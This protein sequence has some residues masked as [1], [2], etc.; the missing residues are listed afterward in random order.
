VGIGQVIAGWDQGI[1]KLAKG[2]KATFT[3]P[4]ELGYGNQQAGPMIPPN[5]TLVFEVELVDFKN[6]TALRKAMGNL[7]KWAFYF[8][9][10]A[11]IINWYFNKYSKF[12]TESEDSIT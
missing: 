2:D 1:L 7:T 10:I 3:I 4:P 12:H 8:I 6:Q 9:I 5:S 11:V